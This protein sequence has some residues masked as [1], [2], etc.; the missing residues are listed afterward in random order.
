MSELYKDVVGCV[1]LSFNRPENEGRFYTE[2]TC[3]LLENM[4]DRQL[5]LDN[6]PDSIEEDFGICCSLEDVKS[7]K[8]INDV[9]EFVRKGL[10][11][12][13]LGDTSS[14]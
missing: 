10:S 7:F 9:V 13:D 6:L 3:L 1:L 12:I 11:P 8:T 2:R 4:G 5:M 14:I